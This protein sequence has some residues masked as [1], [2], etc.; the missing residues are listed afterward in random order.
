MVL[1]RQVELEPFEQDRYERLVAR[2]FTGERDINGELVKLGHAWAFRKYMKREDAAYCTL[3][4]EART[5][6]RGLWGL[7]KDERVAPWE[8]RKRRSLVTFTDYSGESAS[9]CV[10]AIGHQH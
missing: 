10:E 4:A 1:G 3:E 6:K 9:A 7:P 8:W 5:A 2:V